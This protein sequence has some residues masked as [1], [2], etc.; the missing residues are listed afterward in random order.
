MIEFGKVYLD[1][2][3][4]GFWED[5]DKFRICVGLG[6]FFIFDNDLV[7]VMWSINDFFL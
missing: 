1:L 7:I 5:Y 3:F 4:T 6:Y 2:E